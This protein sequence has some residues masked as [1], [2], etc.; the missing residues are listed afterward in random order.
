MDWDLNPDD[1][2][3]FKV[4]HYRCGKQF[5]LLKDIPPSRGEGRGLALRRIYSPSIP[6]PP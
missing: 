4:G 5:E 6:N 3:H 1:S 2:V